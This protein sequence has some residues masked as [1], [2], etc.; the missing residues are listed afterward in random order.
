MLCMRTRVRLVTR[1]ELFVYLALTT[2]VNL[3]NRTPLTLSR[4]FS[5]PP[6]SS[7]FTTL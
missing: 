3:V 4:D 1:A 6:L 5:P 7:L 2:A